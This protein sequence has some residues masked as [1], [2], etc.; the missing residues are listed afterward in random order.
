MSWIF[1]SII[2]YKIQNLYNICYVYCTHS[3]DWYSQTRFNTVPLFL[4]TVPLPAVLS[5]FGIPRGANAPLAIH[6]GARGKK[7]SLSKWVSS[8]KG[9][10]SDCCRRRRARLNSKWSK[11][12][13]WK[14]FRLRYRSP[15]ARGYQKIK[16]NLYSF[17]KSY[18]LNKL[19]CYFCH[20]YILEGIRFI[21]F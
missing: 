9:N 8:L 4:N 21:M 17:K 19:F 13:L 18:F 16:L 14:S 7:L 6:E 1:E 11:L 20:L 2:I 12:V 10:S 3:I 5:S 15:V